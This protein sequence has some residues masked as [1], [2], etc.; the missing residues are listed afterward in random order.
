M[1]NE[2]LALQSCS[3]YIQY[4]YFSKILLVIVLILSGFLIWKFVKKIFEQDY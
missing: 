2:I 3:G 1:A 4:F